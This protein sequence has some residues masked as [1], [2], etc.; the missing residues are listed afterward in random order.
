MWRAAVVFAAVWAATVGVDPASAQQ[1]RIEGSTRDSVTGAPLD[2]V[3]VALLKDGAVRE[4][5]TDPDGRFAFGGVAPG[6]YRLIF[7]RIDYH[8]RVIDALRVGGETLVLVPAVNLTAVAFE[9][10]PIVVTV[11]R[12]SEKALDAPAAV[13]VIDRETVEERPALTPADH[14][15]GQ[16]GIDVAQT[17]LTQHEIV[18][19]GFSNA[20]SGQLLVLT[21]NREASVPSL[22]INLYNFI[23]AT[24]DDVD[25][26]ELV[27]GPGAALYGP[28]SAQGVMH[29]ISRSPFGSE[30][31]S[32]SVG[33]GERS[34]VTASARHA[35]TFGRRLGVRVS[36]QYLRGTDWVFV[37]TAEIV[38]RDPIV[39]RASGE[40]RV[41][42]RASDDATVTV[43]GGLNHALRNVD[44]TS[45]GAA[46]VN[47]W[48][49]RY[50]QAQFTAGRLYAQIFANQSD[51]GSTVL[52]RTNAP[53][54]DRSIMIAA[55][56][57]HGTTWHPMD[58]TYG[59]DFQRTEPRTQ[60]TITGRNEAD[61][62][63]E[64]V[65]AYVHAEA[66]LHPRID[67]VAA[68]RIDYHNRLPDPVFSPRAAL[69]IRPAEDHTVRLTYNRA[70]A[71][72]ST[73]DLFLDL[74]ADSLPFG[75][76]FALRVYGVP[77][78]G[79]RFRRDCD[80][81]L[82]MRSPFTPSGLGG[83]GTY[84]PTD[85]TLL[86]GGLLDSLNASGLLAAAGAQD[87][88]LI[89]APTSAQVGTN[90][91]LLDGLTG[92]TS[93]VGTLA[94][95]PPLSSVTTNTI[96]LGYR[97][98]VGRR[99]LIGIDVWRTTKNNFIGPLRVETPGVYLDSASLAGYLGGFMPADR[100]AAVAA[101]A[102]QL[103]V[104]TVSPI[105][106]RDPWDLIITNRNFGDITLW[107]A[108]LEAG[109]FLT[110]TVSVYATYSVTSDDVFANVD[111][112]ADIALNAPANKGSVR[113][114]YRDDDVGVSAQL[115]GRYVAGF[116]VNSGVY[117]G[118]V[119][120][121]GVVDA[122]IGYRL[123]WY[124]GLT[125]TVAAQNVLDRRH[126]EFVGTPRIGRLVTGR[127]RAEF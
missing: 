72:P 16:A 52:L 119:E 17:G 40:V 86:W 46:Q 39:E 5:V 80:G 103:P 93:P 51:A 49:Y 65:G 1:V 85:A 42:W 117:V 45:I 127:L 66:A 109:A 120:S 50:A 11:S 25:R 69:V 74:I 18:A 76:P 113:I 84:L 30:G 21:D 7:T 41:D 61:D 20:S 108:D 81:G 91:L 37:D 34:L 106:A 56:A 19:R 92:T 23:P 126:A 97:G 54:V 60:G 102:T 89:P 112:I 35:S 43:T 2:G 78:S 70:F 68:A 63:I 12:R 32:I 15:F 62:V 67:V 3:H 31:T 22:R 79:F 4:T 44:I 114:E 115:R 88:L 36:G 83:P 116:P 27:R 13:T 26:I 110:R 82:C 87:L 8:R 94:D 10:N 14:V 28:N 121:Y 122:Q 75:L 96:E 95:L 33:G 98:I 124:R 48:Q 24:N 111:Q 73:N 104:G 90:V 101:L 105:E 125:L 100:A 77:A 71:T 38:A 59:V 64:E 107:G 6:T 99:F 123:P 55:Q 58:L 57:Q 47:D 53:I 29:I 118:A 9:L